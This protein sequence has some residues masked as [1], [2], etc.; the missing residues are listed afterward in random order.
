MQWP[1]HPSQL[2][3]LYVGLQEQRHRSEDIPPSVLHMPVKVVPDSSAKYK[4][5]AS[6]SKYIRQKYKHH[7]NVSMFSIYYGNVF[8]KMGTQCLQHLQL[9]SG[10]L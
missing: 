4:D 5:D 1:Q 10:P 7:T 6:D 2:A 3:F 9:I 8:G